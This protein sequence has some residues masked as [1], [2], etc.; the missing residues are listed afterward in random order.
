MRLVGLYC[1]CILFGNG[2][3]LFQSKRR[4]VAYNQKPLGFKPKGETLDVTVVLCDGGQDEQTVNGKAASSGGVRFYKQ[5][6]G[7]LEEGQEQMAG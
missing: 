5:M 1:V 3:K 6:C 7:D 2:S 4:N